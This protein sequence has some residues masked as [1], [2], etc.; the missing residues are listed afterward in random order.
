VIGND[1]IDLTLARVQSDWQ[2][3]GFI[4]K[5]FTMAEQ[6]IIQIAADP[7]IMVWTLWS[8][9]EAAYKIYN[10]ETQIRR[11]NPLQFECS[12]MQRCDYYYYGTVVFQN[13]IYYSK[14]E[15]NAKFV[16]TV[17]VNDK[18]D[19]D[20]IYTLENS[21]NI[22]KKDGIPSRY[23]SI[24]KTTRPVSISHHGTFKRIISI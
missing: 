5:I 10:R 15:V 2:R 19:F 12:P 11:Y 9:K 7:E 14:T 6:Q 24:L 13:T 20:K 17:A 4:A 23:C 16:D 1:V 8:R 21:E 18:A 22:S 3:K